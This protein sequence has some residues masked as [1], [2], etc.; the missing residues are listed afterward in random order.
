MSTPQRPLA[1]FDARWILPTPSGIGVCARELARRLPALRPDY[2]FVFLCRDAAL[3]E[4]LCADL[5]AA[6]RGNVRCETVPYGPF[7]PKTQLFLPARLRAMGVRLF[8]AP[9]FQLPFG[10]FSP[11]TAGRA[12]AMRC[13]ATIHDVIPL[14]V[15]DYAPASRTARLRAVYR[16]CMRR[17]AR[18]ADVL[19]TVSECSRRDIIAALGLSAAEAGRICVVHNGVDE[20]FRAEGR[21]PIRTLSDPAPRTLL[22]VGRMDPYKNVPALVQ[23]FALAR[24]R[25]PFPVRLVLA[26]PADAR[27]PE[28]PALAEKLG[29]ADGIDFT[30]SVPFARLLELYRSADLLVHPSRYEGFGLQI[31]EAMRSGLPVLCTDGGSA[32]EVAGDAACIVPLDESATFPERLADNIVALL[33][34]PRELARLQAAGAQRGACFSWDRAAAQVAALY[35]PPSAGSN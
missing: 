8:H 19:L 34:D 17:A 2:D 26:G 12:R 3:G 5:P 30:G 15:P 21:A 11:R 6:V 18:S 28:A 33:S 4:R 22:Y 1:A 32:A 14:V 23:A 29:V 13:L 31:A 35:D 25:L 9:N 20:A 10:A 27:Y 16:W 24:P 7:S